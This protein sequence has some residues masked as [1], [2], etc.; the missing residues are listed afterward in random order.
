MSAALMQ[1]SASGAEASV[2]ALVQWQL[3]CKV[4]TEAAAEAALL[5]SRLCGILSGKQLSE[6]LA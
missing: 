1:L 6:P 4:C 2:Q 3:L 5:F